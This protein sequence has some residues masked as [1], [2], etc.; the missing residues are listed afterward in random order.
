MGNSLG[1]LNADKIRALSP[2]H[3]GWGVRRRSICSGIFAHSSD[4]SPL[5]FYQS[6]PGEKGA[7]GQ[8]RPRPAFPLPATPDR[9][10]TGPLDR[11]VR[12]QAP[13]VR[14]LRA[15]RL[16]RRIKPHG[17]RKGREGHRRAL[18]TLLP[19]RGTERSTPRTWPAALRGGGLFFF[20]CGVVDGVAGLPCPDADL[21]QQVGQPRGTRTHLILLI[22]QAL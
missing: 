19:A 1:I 7:R 18:A 6:G 16:G 21:S 2:S 14:G 3:G 4:K 20:D 9:S 17:V 22:L 13:F 11:S 5:P 8:R 10:G 15:G 12:A